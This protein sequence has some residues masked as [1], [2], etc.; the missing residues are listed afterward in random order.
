MK[1]ISVPFSKVCN[2]N[3]NAD[4]VGFSWEGSIKGLPPPVNSQVA[5]DTLFLQAPPKVDHLSIYYLHQD[6]HTPCGLSIYQIQCPKQALAWLVCST[7]NDQAQIYLSEDVLSLLS[8]GWRTE[9]EET[10]DPSD[11][12]YHD[13]LKLVLR[14]IFENQQISLSNLRER[15]HP[16][17]NFDHRD[18]KR[19]QIESLFTHLLLKYPQLEKVKQQ[20]LGD[21]N[22]LLDHFI[23]DRYLQKITDIYATIK[24]FI[25]DPADLRVLQYANHIELC[26][27]NFYAPGM[28]EMAPALLAHADN[29]RKE[30][31]RQAS[32]LLS[33][34]ATVM[35]HIYRKSLDDKRS[36]IS[37][38]PPF[39]PQP[40]SCL[41]IAATYEQQHQDYGIEKQKYFDEI[42]KDTE[43][44]T[45]D[46]E[47]LFFAL[48]KNRNYFQEV[49]AGPLPHLQ[50]IRG[51]FNEFKLELQLEPKPDDNPYQIHVERDGGLD[52]VLEE[53]IR[54]WKDILTQMKPTPS[55][56]DVYWASYQKYT[57]EL[58]G[59]KK[60]IQDIIEKYQHLYVNTYAH[61]GVIALFEEID[62]QITATENICPAKFYIDALYQDNTVSIDTTKLKP[63][64]DAWQTELDAL[65]PSLLS[66]D[67]LT[68]LIALSQHQS[69]LHLLKTQ[70]QDT[71]Q[72]WESSHQFN[73]ELQEKIS[74]EEQI[75]KLTNPQTDTHEM[76]LNQAQRGFWSR[77][78]SDILHI[79]FTSVLSTVGVFFI[80]WSPAVVGI[81]F[82]A[83]KILDI[84]QTEHEHQ[85]YIHKEIPK[86]NREIHV[87]FTN[88]KLPDA[89]AHPNQNLK[90]MSS[91]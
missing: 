45:G 19:P 83:V 41:D 36:I 48:D 2:P 75:V 38:I 76:A 29:L 43:K 88:I 23:H 33:D 39:Q 9:I 12:I 91:I 40:I 27:L 53:Q 22:L 52:Y 56:V 17:Y 84:I 26:L 65:T 59:F 3:P 51:N 55:V 85:K 61:P 21:M 77:N 64:F 31:P 87:F 89:L 72:V 30:P 86:I 54:A 82:V 90:D 67:P 49:I 69:Q 73:G 70:I 28:P 7:D 62:A 4:I 60:Q 32:P 16:D 71:C 18:L 37:Q 5:L 24:P 8:E 34:T 10:T 20:I 11:I 50:R 81:V 58:Q 25:E 15:F 79:L 78:Q 13:V 44:N 57:L 66:G 6:K 80:G 35:S 47:G 42:L 1:K 74:L 63:Q 68:F 46:Y 14:P